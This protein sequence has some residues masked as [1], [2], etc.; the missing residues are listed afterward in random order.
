MYSR[1]STWPKR[2]SAQGDP[3]GS[4]AAAA[5]ANY[6]GTAPVEIASADKARH[7]LSRAGTG[8]STR[9]CIPSR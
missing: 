9:Y 6:C 7:R 3:P 5:Y 2:S 4:P 8:S 1:S